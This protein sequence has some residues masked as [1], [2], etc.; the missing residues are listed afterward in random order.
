MAERPSTARVHEGR[1]A[2]ITA[3]T[4][5]LLVVLGYLGLA[6]AAHWWPFGSQTGS[7]SAGGTPSGRQS[8]SPGAAG[9]GWSVYWSGPVGITNIGLNFDNKPPSSASGDINFN[10]S[11]SSSDTATMAAWPGPRT[12]TAAQCQNWV[13]THPSNIVGTVTTGM[14]ICLLTTQGRSVLLLVEGLPAGATAEL[15]AHATI[16]QQQ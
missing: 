14:Q 8:T 6:A 9:R 5:I 16:W 12:P 4:G 13:T 3:I 1:A 2:W 10:G 7:S 15:Q 11:L